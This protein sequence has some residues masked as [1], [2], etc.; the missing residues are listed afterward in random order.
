M[1]ASSA[2]WTHWVATSFSTCEPCV[3]QL[4]K[5][6]SEILKPLFPRYLNSMG[7][8]V[9]DLPAGGKAS[10]GFALLGLRLGPVVVLGRSKGRPLGLPGQR[11]PAG[12]GDQRSRVQHGLRGGHRGFPEGWRDGAEL[13]VPVRG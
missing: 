5:V 2:A 4:P 11:Q 12:Q 13:A 7:F 3:S 6:I 1:P 10:A 9:V 8:T